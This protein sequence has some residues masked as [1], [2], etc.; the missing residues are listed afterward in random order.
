METYEIMLL[1]KETLPIAILIL[2]D[3][4][5][6]QASYKTG[7]SI[8]GDIQRDADGDI[9]GINPFHSF[10]NIWRSELSLQFALFGPFDQP[11]F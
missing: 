11:G 5:T 6:S 8:L 10:G 4:Q 1:N 7:D 3:N 9:D 2:L